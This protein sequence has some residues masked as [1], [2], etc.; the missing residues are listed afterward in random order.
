MVKL[1]VYNSIGQKVATLLDGEIPAG[2]HEVKFIAAELPSGI[3]FYEI[4]CTNFKMTKKMV[5]LK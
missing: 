1:N 5:L 2:F 3:Y 4:T